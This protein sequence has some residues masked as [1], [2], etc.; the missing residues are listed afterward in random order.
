MTEYQKYQLQWMIDHD[1]SIDELIDELHTFQKDWADS[2]EPINDMY[3]IWERQ[4][5]FGGE[6]WACQREWEDSGKK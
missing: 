6:L 2:D 4:I 1:H 3:F 5:G